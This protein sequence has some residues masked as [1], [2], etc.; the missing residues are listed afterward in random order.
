MPANRA[1]AAQ[2][3]S[4]VTQETNELAVRIHSIGEEN[5][6]AAQALDQVS[7]AMQASSRLTGLSR[8]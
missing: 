7:S 4:Q 3:Q 1:V 2:Q 5:A 6:R 8:G